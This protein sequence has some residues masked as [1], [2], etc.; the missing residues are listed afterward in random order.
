NLS[1]A[2]VAMAKMG[3]AA[4]N[5][6][7]GASSSFPHYLWLCRSRTHCYSF[8]TYSSRVFCRLPD[9]VPRSAKGHL[10]STNGNADVVHLRQNSTY[11][12]FPD[13]E[14]ETLRLQEINIGYPHWKSSRYNENLNCRVRND[15]NKVRD[16]MLH[17]GRI[18]EDWKRA[19]EEF[20]KKKRSS[21]NVI[22]E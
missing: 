14:T 15:G 20:K 4:P 19:T 10:S 5:T 8:S 22:G 3:F 13:K 21:N 17:R 18:A 7:F 1:R 6:H 16:G 9:D 11:A 12:T 2:A